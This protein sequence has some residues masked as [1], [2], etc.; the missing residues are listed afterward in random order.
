MR[1]LRYLVNTQDGSWTTVEITGRTLHGRFLLKPDE[2]V[3][4]IIVGVLARA[5]ERFGVEVNADVFLSGHFHL[6]V[7]VQNVRS[8]SRFMQYV[9]SNIVRKIGRY[10]GWHGRFWPRRYRAIEIS[11]DEAS[12]VECFDYILR[13]GAKELLVASP[14]DWPGLHC[15]KRLA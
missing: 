6:L 14:L 13:H 10:R 8:M 7:N 9:M 12:I 1:T 2:T 5:S 4:R 3:N 11:P 15:A